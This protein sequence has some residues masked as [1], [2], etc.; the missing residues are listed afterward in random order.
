MSNKKI[1]WLILTVIILTAGFIRLYRLTSLPPSLNWDEV[2]HAYNALSLLTTGRDQW[3]SLF[4]VLNYRAYGDYPAVLDTYLI[5]VPVFIFGS[6][7]FAVRLPGAI[8]GV[9]VCLL[10]FVAGYYYFKKPCSALL[11]ALFIAIDPWT[12]FPS[13]AVFQSNFS[14]LFLTLGLTFWLSKKH[15]PAVLFWGISLL[16]YH[17]TR[18]FIPLFLLFLLPRLRKNIRAFQAAILVIIIGTGI[19][20]LPEARARNSWVGI[21]DSGA[22]AAIEEL[23]NHSPLPHSL[24]R[25]LYNRP[26]YFIATVAKNYLGY[27]SPVFLFLRGG[28]Q[29]QFSLPEEGL[30][31]W[32]EL[33]FFYFGLYLLFRRRDKLLL[34]WL[35]LAP[36][37]AAIT[38]DQSAV[39]RATAMLPVVYFASALGFSAVWKKIKTVPGQCLLSVGFI[40]VYILFVWNYFS[41]YFGLYPKNYSASWQYGYRELVVY[42]KQVNFRYDQIIITKRLGEPHEFV[43]WYWPIRP[44]DFQSDSSLSWNYHNSWYW[45]DGFSKFLFVDD[46]KMPDVAKSLV[47]DGSHLVVFSPDH[48]PDLG[49]VVYKINFLDGSPAFILKRI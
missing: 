36:I 32:A 42:L 29:Y 11:I 28:T 9:L 21:L 2:S 43:L 39:I 49:R 6:N 45:V 3:G 13:R 33:P 7:D 5:T 25:L 8:A 47:P 37:P 48:N 17:N 24:S 18:I 14:L 38:R 4:P 34:T 23:R 31:N 26:V 30:L 44:R 46:W 10:G 16:S 27:F 41:N 19:L 22:V 1:H 15:L 12:F 40:L 20:L 35:L